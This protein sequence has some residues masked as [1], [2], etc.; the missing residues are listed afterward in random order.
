MSQLDTRPGFTGCGSYKRCHL[1][2]GYNFCCLVRCGFR[3]YSYTK[4]ESECS[5]Q[6]YEQMLHIHMYVN[7]PRVTIWQINIASQMFEVG[8]GLTATFTLTYATIASYTVRHEMSNMAI[9]TGN[10]DSINSEVH[11]LH[12]NCSEPI[13]V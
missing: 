4:L 12:I 7:L 10:R 1:I 3:I 8:F 6:I 11:L 2:V 9:Q 5:V 13:A